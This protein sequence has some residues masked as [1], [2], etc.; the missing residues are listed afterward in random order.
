MGANPHEPARSLGVNAPGTG[1]VPIRGVEICVLTDCAGVSD[2]QG[3]PPDG[4][5][6]G[7]LRDDV[8]RVE[9][10]GVRLRLEKH[11]RFGE[12]SLNCH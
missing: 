9:L 11:G 3:R 4:R 5:G 2:I 7:R 10:P 8:Q 6:P 1:G 12:D